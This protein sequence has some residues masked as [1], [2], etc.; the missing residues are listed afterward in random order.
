MSSA[1]ESVDSR[2]DM[3]GQT[4][5]CEATSE[6]GI[7]G[8]EIAK[9]ADSFSMAKYVRPLILRSPEN[10]CLIAD[11]RSSITRLS[12]AVLRVDHVLQAMNDSLFTC[13]LPYYTNLLKE[14]INKG[15]AYLGKSQR[16]L[17]KL[18]TIYPGYCAEIH[19]L[20][21]SL[22]SCKERFEGVKERGKHFLPGPELGSGNGSPTPTLVSLQPVS[23]PRH[24]LPDFDCLENKNKVKALLELTERKS[25]V[26]AEDPKRKRHRGGRKRRRSRARRKSCPLDPLY[27]PIV[28]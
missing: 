1:V 20:A 28:Q 7:T 25:T 17:D 2:A 18:A 23:T 12:D 9:S 3:V 10:L 13:M 5:F 24:L 6:A 22:S 14:S 21:T 27:I 11:T 26:E 19:Q 16:K 8:F 4:T 15:E